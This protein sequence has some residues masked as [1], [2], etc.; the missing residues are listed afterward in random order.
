MKKKIKD[1][2][3]SFLEENKCIFKKYKPIKKIGS[4]NFGNIYS[5]IRLNDKSVFAM[6]TE[7]IKS[8]RNILESEA[9][10]L[11]IL[12]GFGIPKLISYGHSKK[13]NILIETLL[14]KSLY[15][16]FIGNNEKTS[17]T[18]VC[19]IGLQI[20]DRLEWIHSKNI[21]HRDVKPD[22]F[23]I[24]INDPN[25]IYIIDFGLCKKYR[26][27]KTGKHI[28]P[29]L[30]G[31]LTGNFRFCSPYVLKGK[32]SSRRDDLI[33]LGYV[34]IY[35]FKK[36]LPWEN[37]FKGLTNMRNL[38]Y[39]KLVFLKDTNGCGKLFENI[40]QELIEYFK[41]TQKLKF[42]Q[43]P[44]Y[45]YLRSLFKKV[46]IF[47]NSINRELTFSWI[48]SKSIEL[49][50]IQSDR[51]KK[52]YGSHSRLLNKIKSNHRK[53]NSFFLENIEE[54][55]KILNKKIKNI[56]DSEK[57]ISENEGKI[58]YFQ[59]N[60]NNNIKII[61]FCRSIKKRNYP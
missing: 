11:F 2:N 46:L 21:I 43:D 57:N 42:E 14:D 54:K 36:E 4:G 40:P 27:S 51:T 38:N 37:L 10:Y 59:N 18:D 9:Y 50:A 8:E 55:S 24:G 60:P 49:S 29:K 25:I 7:K 47:S 6:K 56:N 34:L 33:S 58:K 32:E 26:S 3:D 17:I 35:L 30:T 23:L 45:S 22:N 15:N 28:L 41:Y 16:L 39:S 44:D 13:Y 48:K 5:T 53:I 1:L 52:K 12:Q 20:L 19:L 31:K 61:K